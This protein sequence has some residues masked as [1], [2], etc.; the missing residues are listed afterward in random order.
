VQ[1]RLHMPG[2]GAQHSSLKD[3]ESQEKPPEVK[4]TRAITD[5]GFA[6]LSLLSLAAE[7]LDS[8]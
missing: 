5:V 7:V 6:Y 2:S 1:H 3:F 8:D 4:V